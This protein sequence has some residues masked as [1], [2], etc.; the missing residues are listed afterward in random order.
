MPRGAN[1]TSTSRTGSAS[2]IATRTTLGK[3]KSDVA[4]S[5]F[6]ALFGELVQYHRARARDTHE[7]ERALEDAGRDVGYRLYEVQSFRE[8]GSG[9][10]EHRLLPLLQFIQSVV[11]KNVFGRMADS[12]EVYND[13]EYLMSDRDLLV[14]RF[15]SVPKDL[16]DLNCGAFAAGVVCGVLRSA[17]FPAKVTAYY[18]DPEPGATVRTTNLL[19]K[20]ERA[21]IEREKQLDGR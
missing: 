20:F 6:A 21:V 17:G 4:L 1:A 15:I 3:G 16:G 14:N 9:K 5:S 2:T 11:W 7:L 12:L 10:R 13:D 8:R 18:S 19:M